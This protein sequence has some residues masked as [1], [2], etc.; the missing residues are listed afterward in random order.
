MTS[1]NP[2]STQRFF[3]AAR[4]AAACTAA[5][6]A[7]V[8]VAPDHASSRASGAG[9][10][11]TTEGRPVLIADVPGA[12]MAME[13]AYQRFQTLG[14]DM[15]QAEAVVGMIVRLGEEPGAPTASTRR[16]RRIERGTGA[17][18]TME[19]VERELMARLSGAESDEA[20]R[21]AHELRRRLDMGVGMGTAE[22]VAWALGMAEELGLRARRG[23]A[24]LSA[25]DSN[26]ELTDA[27]LR[28]A[29][30]IAPLVDGCETCPPSAPLGIFTPTAVWQIDSNSTGPSAGS[31]AWYGFNVQAGVSYEFKTCGPEGAAGFNTILDLFSNACGFLASNDNGP[32]CAPASYLTFGP[33]PTTEQVWLKV[34]GSSGAVGAYQLAYRRTCPGASDCASPDGVLSSPT[35]A[36]QYEA[37]TLDACTGSRFYEVTLLHGQTYTFTLCPATCASAFATFDSAIELYRGAGIVAS[38]TSFCGDDAEVVFTTNPTTDDT[39][40]VH[41][42]TEGATG[43]DFNLGYRVA[44]QAPSDLEITPPTASTIATDCIVDQAFGVSTGGTGEFTVDWTVAPQ[45]GNSASPGAGSYV[46]AENLSNFNSVLQGD[47]D[48]VVTVT[49]TNEC[50]TQT[51]SITYHL[52]D[53]AGPAVAGIAQAVS[54]GAPF[55]AGTGHPRTNADRR[56]APVDRRV[57]EST[58]F[59]SPDPREIEDLLAAKLGVS[60]A[61]VRVIDSSV[62]GVIRPPH[63]MALSCGT[64][65]TGAVLQ[66][67]N[68][69][70]EVFV[71]CSNGAFTA[72]TGPSHD[73]TIASGSA[74]NV[75]FGG[76]GGGPGTSDITFHVHET[77]DNFLDPTGGSACLFTPPFNPSEPDAAGI[78]VEWTRA[79]AGG[80]N[81]TMREEMVA[82]GDTMDNSGIRLTLGATNSAGSSTPVTMG[83]RWQIDYQNGGDDGPHYAQVHCQP[84][85]IFNSRSTEHEFTP[86][87]IDDQDFYRIQNNTGDPIFGNFTSTAELS[88]FPGTDK[89]DRLVY[90]LWGPM[91]GSAWNY[92][93]SEGS[94]ADFDSAVLYYFGYQPADGIVIAPG[95]TFQRS[96][97]IFTAGESTDCGDFRPG[98]CE[99]ATVTICPGECAR[100]G[101]SATDN[102]GNVTVSFVSATPGA[103][104]CGSYPC[105]MQFPVAGT[106]VYTFAATD[107]SGNSEECTATVIVEDTGSCNVPPT[108]NAGGPYASP[109]R[110]ATVDGA[111]VDDLDGDTIT[112]TWTVDRGDVTITPANG[113]VPAGTGAR[114]IPDTLVQ[115]DP[116]TPPCGVVAT[117]T[118]TVDDGNG[119]TSSCTTTVTFSDTEPPV[120]TGAG[121][122]AGPIACMWPPNH[123]YVPFTVD[124]L[125]IGLTDNCTGA[126]WRVTG[127]V[128]DQP[129][130]APESGSDWNGDGNTEN[131]CVVSADGRTV[132]VRSERCGTGPTAQ[133]GRHYGLAVVATDDCGNES[134]PVIAGVIHVPHDQSPH[135]RGCRNPTHEGVRLLP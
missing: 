135:E 53:R 40:C 34:R 105:V 5:L 47:G 134:A 10:V 132:Y 27:D 39:Y 31:C 14:L 114:G 32:G 93:T 125:D 44:C 71:N 106:Y 79:L 117:L 41:V 129:D 88:G 22:D 37:G 77:G 75:I 16:D 76:A 126:T 97:I 94:N 23:S 127:C 56:Y 17:T 24:G 63:A 69:Y 4:L 64:P 46:T 122:G 25:G 51:T 102:C 110:E 90:G 13:L 26:P 18:V 62:P 107:D 89:P 2:D 9:A 101:A 61:S 65:C 109:C 19:E 68:P 12:P 74:Q 131:D 98:N 55:A 28:D 104:T 30:G 50:G 15:D 118:L 45:P 36:C 84:F 100:V 8:L 3:G 78:E 96:V 92:V 66:A 108:C 80:R 121:P 54:C 57:I 124:L 133:D 112:Y 103:P 119:G 83:V 6:A 91:S 59:A 111:S 70:Y 52:E 11:A 87:E 42:Y 20:I 81:I 82:F 38:D 21:V 73:V 115:L 29:G 120:V 86:A 60:S 1:R 85:E 43:G 99:P 95:E 67:N 128:S 35:T 48:Y 7:L 116:A 130:D 58:M 49:V 113:V 33:A 123:W 72:R